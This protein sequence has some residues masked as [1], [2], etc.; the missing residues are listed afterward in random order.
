[1]FRLSKRK[2]YASI[3][4]IL[5]SLEAY[6]SSGINFIKALE[7]I[8][9]GLSNKA[10]KL[11]VNRVIKRLNEGESIS[12]AF[13]DEEELYT[14][15][16]SD[17][18]I[19]AEQSGQIELVLKNM[20]EHFENKLALNKEIKTATLYP[21]LLITVSLIVFMGFIDFVLPEIIKMYDDLEVELNIITRIAIKINSFFEIYNVYLFFIVIVAVVGSLY[22]FIKWK[23]KN[24]DLIAFIPIRKRYKELSIVSILKLVIESGVPLVTALERLSHSIS[25]KYTRDY[26]TAILVEIKKGEDI[27]YAIS[28]VDVMSKVSRSFFISGEKSGRLDNTTRKLS[29]ILNKNFSRGLKSMVSKIEPLSICFLGVIVLGLVLMVFIPMY[30]YMNYV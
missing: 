25:E 4:Y 8:E 3:V 24:I 12:E 22:L 21:K 15:V 10:Y 6:I 29:D 14:S 5:S 28:K 11:S 27:S 19:V 23:F 1:M 18:L 9:D 13:L 17:M 26:I 30:D 2:D 7:L 20:T 16:F